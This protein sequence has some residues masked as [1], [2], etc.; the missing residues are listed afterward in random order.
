MNFL[1]PTI[2]YIFSAI[3]FIGV[4][5]ICNGQKQNY[6]EHITTAEGLSQN[7]VNSIYQDI[8]GYM[9]FGTHDGLDKYDGYDFHVFKPD[10][11]NDKS[12]NSNLIFSI[13]GDKKGNLWIGTTGNGLSYLNRDTG[14][15]L[16][17][18]HDEENTNSL[19]NNYVS[20]VL[21]SSKDKLWIG[22]NEGIN[23]LNLQDSIASNNFLRYNLDHDP[24]KLGAEINTIVEIYEDAKGDIWVGA[25][26]GLYMLTRDNNNEA[27]FKYMN[28]TFNLPHVNTPSITQDLNGNYYIGTAV[29]LFFINVHE[30]NPTAKLI[31]EGYYNELIVDKQNNIWAGTNNG[32]VLIENKGNTPKLVE[33]YIYNPRNEFSLTKNIVK[34]LFVDDTGI[35][36][37]GTNGGGVNKFDPNRKKFIHVKKTVD[38]QSLSYDKIRSMYQDS[39]GTVWI[40]TEGG[41]LN[42][43]VSERQNKNQV[44]FMKYTTIQRAFVISEVDYLGKKELWI[45]SEGYPNLYKLNM[46]LKRPIQE[47]DFKPSK[48]FKKSVFSIAQDSDKNIWVGTYSGGVYRYKLN[49][50]MTNYD[51]DNFSYKKGDSK[52]LSNNIIRN[53]LE[54]NK[55]NIW[56]ATGNGL[57]VLSKKER[58]SKNP[59]FKKYKN[60]KGDSTSLSHNYILS[61]YEDNN[62]TMWVGTFGGGLNKVIYDE[63]SKEISFKVYSEN[64]GLPNNVIKGIIED[65]SGNL[66]ISTNQ[67]LSMFNPKTEVFTN[68]DV[69]DGLQSNEFQEL[70]CLKKEDGQLLFGGVNGY[71]A[72]YPSEIEDNKIPSKTVI[73]NLLINNNVVE[74]GERI[75]NNTVLSQPIENTSAVKLNYNQNSFSFEFAALHYAAPQKNKFEYKLE[76]FDEDWMQTTASK[77]FATYTNIEPGL[78]TFKVKSSNNDGVWDSRPSVLLIEIVPPFWKTDIAYF[79]YFLLIIVI[80]VLFWRY[81][82]IN[83][84]KKH[85]LELDQMEKEQAEELQRLKLEFF[86][87]ISHEFRTP[88]TLI[89]GPLEYLQKKGENLSWETLQEQFGLMNKNTDSL[90]RLVNQLLDFRKITQGKMRLVVRNTDIIS[91]IKEVAEPFQ[92]LAQKK[93]IDFKIKTND[94]A[95]KAWFDHDALE[96]IINNLLSNAFKFTPDEGKIRIKIKTINQIKISSESKKMDF[97]EIEVRNSGQGISKEKLNNIFERF[98]VDGDKKDRNPEGMGIGLSFVK[99]LV[100]LH[101]GEVTVT[102]KENKGTK[103]QILLPK[104]KEAYIN[105]PEITCKETSDSDYFV[106]TS[107]SESFAIDINDDLVDANLSRTRSKLPVLLVVDDN[108]D[109]RTFIKQALKDDYFIYE[110][111]NGQEGLELAKKYSPNIILTDLLMPIMDGIELCEKLKTNPATSH[112]P[113]IMIT[114]KASQESEVEGLKNGADDYIRKPFDMDA[115]QIKILNTV[116]QRELLRKRFNRE[117]HLQP[118]EVTV[119]STDEKFLNQAMEIVEKHMMNTDFNVEMLVKEMGYSRS[120]LYLKFKELTGLTSSEFIRNIRLKRAVQ[121]LESSDLTVK[122]VMYRTGFNTASY[123]SKCFKKQFG[124]IPSEYVVQKEVK[125]EK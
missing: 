71:N 63:N 97:I 75:G 105:I 22:T 106:R 42:M 114:A 20:K 54:D 5:P 17:F 102:S 91:F 80:L 99:N 125:L 68:Y 43:Q 52:S 124:V 76:G 59:A 15:F 37:I 70:A 86:T 81:T 123:F 10:P 13:T 26:Y 112:I 121:L 41:G 11:N 44:R 28:G 47:K 78:Y 23:M 31:H 66:W 18:E 16:N 98:Y 94:T 61:L 73:T 84:S 40:G 122:E 108:K 56:F 83:A 12:I 7:D 118:N 29:G 14:N 9:W 49:S 100:K 50:Q 115:L 62:N 107:E 8:Y 34:S 4:I 57:S 38:S 95:L 79:I 64:S 111:E 6:F 85:Q 58:N 69:N 109:I 120:N 45:G 110:A 24:T 74:V 32:L 77:R 92:F 93:R 25:T 33:K 48:D 35:I 89:K 90:L 87:N 1:K 103:F 119:T 113:I 55:G 3:L 82:V 60:I 72:F 39:N 46:E 21:L 30:E 36:W 101:E 53:I 116:K 65:N 51:I 88:L 19:S 96:K 104:D 2:Y 27:Y 67:G 117:I